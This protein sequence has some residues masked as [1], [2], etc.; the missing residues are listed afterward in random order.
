MEELD[1]DS[2]LVFGRLPR[3]EQIKALHSMLAY[4]RKEQANDK[5]AIIDMQNKMTSLVEDNRYLKGELAG[6]SMRRRDDNLSTVEK[7]Q[8][9]F[10]KK[11]EFWKPIS[12]H[13]VGVMLDA[14]ILAVLYLAFGGKIP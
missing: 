4:V 6:I 10:D 13:V 14:V 9:A 8:F 12:Q 3:E 2:Q 11:F 5:R 1:R 7:I